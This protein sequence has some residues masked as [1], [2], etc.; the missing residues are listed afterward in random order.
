[1]VEIRIIGE[2]DSVEAWVRFLQRARTASQ[3]VKV[4][5]VSRPARAERR[6]VVAVRRYV[7]AH[8]RDL[9]PGQPR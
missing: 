1:M 8:L 4:T 6:S 3:A 5:G 2:P 7:R 9:D